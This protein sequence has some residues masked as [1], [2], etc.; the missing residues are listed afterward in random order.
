[1]HIGNLEERDIIIR[2]DTEKGKETPIDEKKGIYRIAELMVKE[3]HQ[4]IK[5]GKID[6]LNELLEHGFFSDKKEENPAIKAV[7]EEER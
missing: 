7:E 6:E 2:D 4:Y 1:M 5:E 3:T